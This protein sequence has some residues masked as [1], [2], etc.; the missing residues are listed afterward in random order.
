MRIN[1]LNMKPATRLVDILVMAMAAYFA[2]H[3]GAGQIKASHSLN[4]PTAFVQIS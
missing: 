1:I 3:A 4:M 2:L